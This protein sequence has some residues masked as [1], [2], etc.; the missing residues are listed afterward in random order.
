M[1]NRDF[2]EVESTLEE[3]ASKLFRLLL[4]DGWSQEEAKEAYR[5]WI[6]EK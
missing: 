6:D 3:E 1:N 4:E 5:K 2:I